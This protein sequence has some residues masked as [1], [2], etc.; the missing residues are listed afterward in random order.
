MKSLIETFQAARHGGNTL[1]ADAQRAF[2]AA[3]ADDEQI[4]GVDREGVRMERGVL[5]AIA[6]GP[7]PFHLPSDLPSGGETHRPTCSSPA[8]RGRWRSRSDRS[9]S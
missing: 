7:H 1:E 3:Y 8:G 9:S 6:L 5:P 4:A 2:A